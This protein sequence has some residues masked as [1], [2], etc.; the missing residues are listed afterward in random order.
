MPHTAW[1]T[2]NSNEVIG[3]YSANWEEH[4]Q[5]GTLLEDA[6]TLDVDADCIIAGIVSW[7]FKCTGNEDVGSIGECVLAWPPAPV[8]PT[9][10]PEFEGRMQSGELYAETNRRLVQYHRT[11]QAFNDRQCYWQCRHAGYT[12]VLNNTYLWLRPGDE[13]WHIPL[14]AI[15]CPS[16]WQNRNKQARVIAT[17]TLRKH[18]RKFRELLNVWKGVIDRDTLGERGFSQAISNRL[19]NTL[20]LGLVASNIHRLAE[21][22][23]SERHLSLNYRGTVLLFHLTFSP[24]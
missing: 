22:D 10:W 12:H 1:L 24:P 8:M 13:G 5:T 6:S 18:R 7:P 3:Q 11:W 2:C 20:G 19:K 15:L 16:S 4:L 23:P 14:F 9:N 17:D 21:F